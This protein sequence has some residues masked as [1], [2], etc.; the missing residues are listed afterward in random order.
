MV[1]EDGSAVDWLHADSFGEMITAMKLEIEM[2]IAETRPFVENIAVEMIAANAASF[3]MELAVEMIFAKTKSF[4]ENMIDEMIVAD[5]TLFDEINPGPFS[6]WYEVWTEATE[7]DAEAVKVNET[8]TSADWY[9]CTEATGA[10]KAT[11]TTKATGATGATG[12]SKAMGAS[13]VTSA[14]DAT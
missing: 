11:E 12:A 1:N 2:I 7:F 6:S 5:A 4:V 9:C 3:A 8:A 13:E 10:T 14:S